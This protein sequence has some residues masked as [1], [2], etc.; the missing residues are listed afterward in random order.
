MLKF[1]FCFSSGL[2]GNAKV[3]RIVPFADSPYKVNW[4]RQLWGTGARAPSTPNCLILGGHFRAAQTLTFDFMWLPIQQKIFGPI[5][6]AL[7]TA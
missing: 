2:G 4:R 7:F 5:A 6:L 3:T 1:F